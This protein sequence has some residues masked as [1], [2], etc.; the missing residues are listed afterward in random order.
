M[1][2]K[3]TLAL[4]LSLIAGSGFAQPDGLSLQAG[5]TL[6]SR[7]ELQQTIGDAGQAE[8]IVAGAIAALAPSLA[9]SE[10]D[11]REFGHRR[12]CSTW[13]RSC[14][15]SQTRRRPRPPEASRQLTP[16]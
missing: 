1:T 2:L 14:R 11:P 15:S 9:R 8:A 6:Q 12:Q 3:A 4:S 13:N 7:E 5:V 16:S 10:K